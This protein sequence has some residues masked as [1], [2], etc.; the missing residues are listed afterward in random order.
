M[1]MSFEVVEKLFGRAV[2]DET[3]GYVE[4]RRC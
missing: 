1:D 4:Y 2:A 3:A